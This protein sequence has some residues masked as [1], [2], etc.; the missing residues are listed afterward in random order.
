MNIQQVNIDWPAPGN[1][2]AVSTLRTGGISKAPYNSFNLASHVGDDQLSVIENRKRLRSFFNLSTEPVWLEQ[3]HSNKVVCL[4]EEP[5]NLQADASYSS[6]PDTICTVL[7]ADCLPVLICNESGTEI[8]AI[9]AGWRGLL[10]GIIENTINTFHDP[11]LLVWLG[12]AIGPNLFEVGKDVQ[13]AFCKKSSL[14]SSAFRIQ[15]NNK[16]LMDIYQLSR[17]ILAEHGIK[18]VFGGKFCTVAEKDRF[19]SYRRESKTGRMATLIWRN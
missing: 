10:S 11:D 16:W 12:P 8:A 5:L 18:K 17:I 19:F 4:D 1:V 2:H 9:H 6:N 7:T 14:F 15:K 3:I 13:I